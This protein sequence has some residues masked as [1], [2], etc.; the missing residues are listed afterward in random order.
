MQYPDQEGKII[1]TSNDGKTGKR[2]PKLKWFDN[3]FS[4]IQQTG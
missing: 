3:L 2:F 4:H 1:Y